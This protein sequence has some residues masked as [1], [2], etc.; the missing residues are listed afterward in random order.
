MRGGETLALGEG[1][2]VRA[3]VSEHGRVALGRV[4]YPGEVA[5]DLRPPLRAGAYRHGTVFAFKVEM[6]GRTLVH[7]GSAHVPPE[8]VGPCDVLF[9][10]VSGWR[11]VPEFVPRL[12]EAV[13]ARGGG[14][15]SL[16]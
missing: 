16:G 12:L 4:P 7:V 2:T 6:G 14:A 1:L 13:A 9:V 15:V 11:R 5:G 8:R 10:C 3:I